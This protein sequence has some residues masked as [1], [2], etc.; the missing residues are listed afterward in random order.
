MPKINPWMLSLRT[1][2]PEAL[3]WEL[4]H[5]VQD[6][7]YTVNEVKGLADYPRDPSDIEAVT[8][9]DFVAQTLSRQEYEAD[10][11]FNGVME[12][13]SISQEEVFDTLEKLLTY[14]NPD[15]RVNVLVNVFTGSTTISVFRVDDGTT[16]LVTEIQFTASTQTTESRL[17]WQVVNLL[18]D[19]AAK[20]GTDL[21]TLGYLHSALP[22]LVKE[23]STLEAVSV[24]VDRLRGL[25]ED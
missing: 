17:G 7:H 19:L 3:T 12:E 5:A 6:H 23:I 24:N 15:Y 16:I 14:L 4:N 18:E 13:L 9:E 22:D 21:T 25:I 8:I 2:T 11:P 1:L 10:V 20:Q